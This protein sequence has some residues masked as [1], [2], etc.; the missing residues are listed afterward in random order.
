MLQTISFLS[1]P[2]LAPTDVP[3]GMTIGLVTGELLESYAN[4][5]VVREHSTSYY[6][7]RLSDEGGWK[8][9]HWADNLV[10]IRPVYANSADVDAAQGFA[11][12]MR[13]MMDMEQV[14]FSTENLYQAKMHL[15]DVLRHYSQDKPMQNFGLTLCLIGEA[16]YACRYTGPWYPNCEAFGDQSLYFTQLSDAECLQVSK[17]LWALELAGDSDQD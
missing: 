4:L 13:T 14:R 9:T 1:E 8:P 17:Q 6:S 16:E 15:R 12:S 11:Q 7:L 2:V 5:L 3:T 10:E